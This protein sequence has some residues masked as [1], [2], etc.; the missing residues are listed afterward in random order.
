MHLG[1]R[2]S[3][4]IKTAGGQR[5]TNEEVEGHMINEEGFDTN[6][7]QGRIKVKK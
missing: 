5:R 7:E 4:N 1:Y 3:Q 6:E 2:K